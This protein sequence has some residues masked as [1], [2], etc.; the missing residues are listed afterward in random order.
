MLGVGDDVREAPG[1]DR[2]QLSGLL[3]RIAE[4]VQ[5]G[6]SLGAEDE[7]ARCQLL[8]AVLVP[9]DGTTT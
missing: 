8:F 7:V 2:E 3:G 6:A 1:T 4:R 9:E 5:S